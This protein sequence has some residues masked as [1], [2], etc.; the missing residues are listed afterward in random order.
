MR[1]NRSEARAP[2]DGPN[3][4]LAQAYRKQQCDDADEDHS[5]SVALGN[6]SNAEMANHPT[7]FSALERGIGA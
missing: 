4:H 6:R 1:G 7:R 2:G 3:R 5:V